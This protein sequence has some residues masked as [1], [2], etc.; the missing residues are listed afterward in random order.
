[1]GP[2][3]DVGF[4]PPAGCTPTLNA[5]EIMLPPE[6]F[7]K[8]PAAAVDVISFEFE[9]ISAEGLDLLASLRPVRPA[10]AVLRISQDRIAEKTFLNRAGVATAPWAPAG[11]R[12]ELEE[13]VRRLRTVAEVEAGVKHLLHRPRRKQP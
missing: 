9:N 7:P 12:Q 8:Y 10:P 4:V 11:S 5:Y 2:R 3:Y 13:A 1:M 6:D